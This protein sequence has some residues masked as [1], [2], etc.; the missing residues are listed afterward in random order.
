MSDSEA[1]MR[2]THELGLMDAEV[3][4]LAGTS[5]TLEA[6]LSSAHNQIRCLLGALEDERKI[7]SGVESELRRSRQE[8]ERLLEMRRALEAKLELE[9]AEQLRISHA[10][11]GTI[12]RNVV[13]CSSAPHAPVMT[14]VFGHA[15]LLPRGL[16]RLVEYGN[17][18]E[19]TRH[20]LETSAHWRAAQD[21]SGKAE[22]RLLQLQ[23]GMAGV[24]TT[25]RQ[26]RSE[27]RELRSATV[28]QLAAVR[29]SATSAVEQACSRASR[30]EDRARRA[31]QRTKGLLLRLLEAQR[32]STSSLKRRSDVIGAHRERLR[33]LKTTVLSS[34]F[35]AA[36]PVLLSR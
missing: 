10:S 26:L 6:S 8:V 13:V 4:E 2:A 31:E 7:R 18:A 15:E 11:K 17:A 19:F 36:A 1:E 24:G 22:S 34:H 5:A 20:V 12:D 3:S 27:N 29:A 16:S 25:I 28:S 21:Q 32:R 33:V 23:T 9:A 35:A 14:V 30:S